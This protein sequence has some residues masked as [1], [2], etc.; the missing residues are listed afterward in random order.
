VLSNFLYVGRR[1]QLEQTWEAARELPPKPTPQQVKE[2]AERYKDPGVT[3]E[4][5]AGARAELDRPKE[6]YVAAPSEKPVIVGTTVSPTTGK[7][8]W[9]YGEGEPVVGAAGVIEP[10]RREGRPVGAIERARAEVLFTEKAY[11]RVKE[12]EPEIKKALEREARPEP[13]SPLEAARQYYE[14]GRQPLYTGEVEVVAPPR[15]Y[16]ISIAPGAVKIDTSKVIPTLEQIK[17]RYK[18]PKTKE[19][20]EAMEARAREVEFRVSALG[21]QSY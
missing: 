2:V 5:I 6:H 17:E 15:K 18:I 20:I 13:I 8:V 12:I 11:R 1:Q 14:R 21:R 4:A 3:A 16:P 19:E 9:V 10:P 7:R